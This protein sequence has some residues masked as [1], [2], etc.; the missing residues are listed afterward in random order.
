IKEYEE[1]AIS[2]ALNPLRL[3]TLTDK[4]KAVRLTCPLFD[5]ARWV[6]N[7]ERAYMKMWNLYCSGQNPQPFKVTENVLD[8]PCDK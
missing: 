4:L 2:L 1:R 7:L 6:K 8:F 3:Q 5:T